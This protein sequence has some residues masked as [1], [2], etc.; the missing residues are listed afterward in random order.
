MTNRKHEDG[1]YLQHSRK[2][3]SNASLQNGEISFLF[4]GLQIFLLLSLDQLLD[5]A[6]DQQRLQAVL[7]SVGSK[8]TILSLIQE[9]KTQ[10]EVSEMQKAARAALV[11]KCVPP[12]QT[13]QEIMHSHIL[14]ICSWLGVPWLSLIVASCVVGWLQKLDLAMKVQVVDCCHCNFNSPA[15]A[16][17]LPSHPTLDPLSRTRNVGE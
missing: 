7:S 12:A 4:N 11:P 16:C 1:K 9:A 3:F 15:A 17:H 2:I 10:S 5:S 6:G 8:S 13:A 14:E